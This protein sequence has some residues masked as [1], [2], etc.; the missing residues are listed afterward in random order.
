MEE[1]QRHR[2][3]QINVELAQLTAKFQQNLVDATNAVEWL[4]TEEKRRSGLPESA[5]EAAAASARLKGKQ[6]WRFTLQAPSRQAVL[7]FADDAT[8]RQQVWRASVTLAA[9]PPFDN[10]PVIA[11]QLALRREKAALLG[12]ANFADLQ[13]E[14]RMAGSGEGVKR[15]LVTLEE[16]ARPGFE[17]DRAELQAFRRSLEGPNAAEIQAWDVEYYAEKLRQKQ[18]ALDEE[19][20]RPYYPIEHVIA[21]LFELARRLYGI[22]I[23]EQ[24]TAE[25]W[26]PDVK[27]FQVK[28]ADGSLLGRF[29]SDWFPRE[30]KRSGAW[31]SPVSVGGPDQGQWRPHLGMI[32]GNVTPPVAGKPALLT[33]REVETIFREFGHLL[34]LL[35]GKSELRG[36]GG[37]R[38]AWD[39]VELPSQIME[40]FTWER[41]VLDLVAAHYETGEKLPE[42][43]FA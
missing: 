33:H 5:K 42:V 9:A 8:W 10:R 12:Y 37:I 29:Y 23:V 17:K 13:T 22:Q 24:K 2:L 7:R 30:N 16:R 15:F 35:F 21:G 32:V 14:D 31:M 43:S 38:V 40:N 41:P 39:F 20:L 25:V 11:Q 36:L 34:H 27:F 6:G 3:Q 28:D 4:I 19:Q 18:F 26:H 1:A